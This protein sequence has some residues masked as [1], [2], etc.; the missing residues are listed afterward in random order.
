M[1]EG[2]DGDMYDGYVTH[3]CDGVTAGFKYFDMKDVTGI[4]I[5]TRGYYDGTVEV[6]NTLDGPVKGRIEGHGSNVWTAHK[7]SFEPQSGVLALYLTYRGE[8]TFSLRSFELL[9]GKE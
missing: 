7:C 8:G 6:R 4:R 3:I 1:Q 2:G 5:W 9:H